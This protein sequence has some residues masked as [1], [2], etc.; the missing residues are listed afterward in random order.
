MCVVVDALAGT[1]LATFGKHPELSYVSRMTDSEEFD[2][3]QK[4]DAF[5][6]QISTNDCKDE[7]IEN[8]GEITPD[9]VTAMDA[10]DLSTAA[11]AVEF[12]IAYVHETRGCPVYFFSGSYFGDV[13]NGVRS[14]ES[15]SGSNYAK[16]VDT[17]IQ[18]TEKWDQIDGYRVGV[19]DLYNNAEF[20]SLISDSDYEYMMQDAIHPR[21]AGYLVWWLPEFQQF[22]YTEFNK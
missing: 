22:L 11:G 14:N 5:F 19:L 2:Q 16:L 7:N 4:I 12:I 8:F 3:D 21:K 6:C 17:V 13:G 20:N 10:F 18:I 9:D 1:T 15:P